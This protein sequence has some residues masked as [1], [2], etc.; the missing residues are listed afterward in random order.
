MIQMCVGLHAKC[1]YCCQ[2]SMKVGFSRQ[3][4]QKYSNIKF[5]ENL[6]SGSRAVPCGRTDGRTYIRRLTVV[7]R[8]FANAP[9][10]SRIDS[11]PSSLRRSKLTHFHATRR[12]AVRHK[13]T[14]L[15]T[16]LFRNINYCNMAPMRIFDTEDC[17]I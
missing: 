16:A 5:H 6:S 9:K 7:S 15:R 11:A 17:G 3:F 8:N 12:D 4:S 1:G 2:A 10:N 13:P 14:A